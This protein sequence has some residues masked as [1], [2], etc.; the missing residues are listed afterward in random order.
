MYNLDYI[1]V[2]AEN[3][4]KSTVTGV[5]RYFYFATHGPVKARRFVKELGERIVEII[6]GPL[7]SDKVN[8]DLLDKTFRGLLPTD[9][10]TEVIAEVTRRAYKT[11]FAELIL[12]AAVSD[13]SDPS[14]LQ[15]VRAVLASEKP[16]KQKKQTGGSGLHNPRVLGGPIPTPGSTPLIPPSA[17]KKPSKQSG[18]LRIPFF[19]GTMPSPQKKP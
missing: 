7:S 3:R 15:E 13:V 4:Q 8:L 14:V 2:I 12:E 19:P 5:E 11:V 6:N 17:P 10:A 18:P 9:S 16:P 1:K